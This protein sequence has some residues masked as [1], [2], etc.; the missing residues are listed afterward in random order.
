MGRYD[1]QEAQRVIDQ[2]PGLAPAHSRQLKAEVD[3]INNGLIAQVMQQHDRERADFYAEQK[4]LDDRLESL[5][6]EYKALKKQGELGRISA[7][8]FQA[9]FEELAKEQDA[10][11]SYLDTLHNKDA[12]LRDIAA[13]PLGYF[14]SLLSRFPALRRPDYPS[15]P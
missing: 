6:D 11:E 10:A 4:A 9:K 3:R 2:T 12:R 15:L 1:P 7:A 5:R 8:D 14:C 13:D